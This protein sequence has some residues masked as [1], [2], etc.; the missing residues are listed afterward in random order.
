[1]SIKPVR[2]QHGK[3]G[4]GGKARSPVTLECNHS[5]KGALEK[6]EDLVKA[7]KTYESRIH[8]SQL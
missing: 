6:A 7:D 2:M 4:G 1:M 8:V 3:M 5:R